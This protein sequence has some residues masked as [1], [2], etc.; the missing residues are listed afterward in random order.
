VII[1]L[2]AVGHESEV[3]QP[4]QAKHP[5]PA[6][7]AKRTA[8]PRL[9]IVVLPFNARFLAQR[10]RVIEGMRIAGVPE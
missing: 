8:P 5:F 3:G 6:S 9:S 1:R 7:D 2:A 10:E 4:S